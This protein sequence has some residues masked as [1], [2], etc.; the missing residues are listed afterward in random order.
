MDSTD[1]NGDPVII[2]GRRDQNSVVNILTLN[3]MLTSKMSINFRLRH[4]WMAAPYYAYYRLREDG[5]LDPS[6]YNTDSDVNFNQFNIDFDYIWNFAPGSQL[7]VMW[8]NAI[9]TFSN[10]VEKNYFNDLNLTLA[11][12]SSN[13]F[14]IRFLY[15]ID[16][17]YFKKKKPKTDL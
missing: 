3:Y 9:T 12:P 11:S 2:F 13:S 6:T 10:D 5:T 15:Y 14:S 17:L 16:A 4:Y 7:S 1:L 8:K